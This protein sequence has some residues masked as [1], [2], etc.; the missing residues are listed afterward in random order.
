MTQCD[1]LLAVP[2]SRHHRDPFLGTVALDR[3]GRPQDQGGCQTGE[4]LAVLLVATRLVLVPHHPVEVLSNVDRLWRVQTVSHQQ[5]VDENPLCSSSSKRSLQLNTTDQALCAVLVVHQAH[6]AQGQRVDR[7]TAPLV[8]D[9]FE[10]KQALADLNR[11]HRHPLQ[12]DRWLRWIRS[13][14]NLLPE[15]T[16]LVPLLALVLLPIHLLVL[17]DERLWHD[18]RQAPVLVRQ[19]RVRRPVRWLEDLHQPAAIH[20]PCDRSAIRLLLKA[21]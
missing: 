11:H 21:N 13:L 2:S 18:R 5:L 12:L 10:A 7:Q 9:P 15:H 1:V 17:L 8:H 14:L 6:H 16:C 19:V 4:H 20:Y 3:Q